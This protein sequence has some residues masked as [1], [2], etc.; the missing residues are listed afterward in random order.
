MEQKYKFLKISGII[1]KVLAYISAVFFVI[2]A[3]IVLV[4]AGGNTPR[5]AS[6][7]FL[8]GGGLY[9]LV[10][11]SVAEVFKV[12]ISVATNCEALSKKID[13]IDALIEG[14]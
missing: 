9:F 7:I 2:V 12:I 4:G 6:I 13:K 11:F 14:K 3:I 8:L 1:F 5:V 10:L